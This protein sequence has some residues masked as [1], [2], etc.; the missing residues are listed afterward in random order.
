MDWT[1]LGDKV[2]G[3]S[4]GGAALNATLP[5]TKQCPQ[6]WN[7]LCKVH[8]LQ[9]HGQAAAR[10][11]SVD[12]SS[13]LDRMFD[14]LVAP[15]IARAQR[16]L[17]VKDG[18]ADKRHREEL[19]RDRDKKRKTRELT[20]DARGLGLSG[21][22][23]NVV[24]AMNEQSDSD[25]DSGSGGSRAKKKRRKEEKKKEKKRLKKEAKKEAKK[26]LKKEKKK[27]SKKESKKSKKESSSSDS[28]SD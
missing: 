16:E 11:T 1:R 26:L 23:A 7:K 22:N 3:G 4:R 17:D 14:A 5:K 15:Q 8:P 12:T 24:N 27:K 18:A 2:T 19:S 20:E 21:L 13:T 25:S 28:D 9:D 10:L 6:C